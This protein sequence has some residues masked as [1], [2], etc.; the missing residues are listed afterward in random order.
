M[1][2]GISIDVKDE[3]ADIGGY[4]QNF[5]AEFDGLASFLKDDGCDLIS[6]LYCPESYQPEEALREWF[7]FDEDATEESIEEAIAYNK[8]ITTDSHAPIQE[9]FDR[10]T[11]ARSLI[12]DYDEERFEHGKAPLLEDLDELLTALVPHAGE[13]LEIQ[14]MRG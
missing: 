7:A 4:Y 9:V 13:D 5:A 11:K 12:A 10:L 14:L 1:S 2:T 6:Y 3:K 8:L